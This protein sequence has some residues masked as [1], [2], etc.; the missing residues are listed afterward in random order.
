MK[1]TIL[2]LSLAFATLFS[3]GQTAQEKAKFKNMM[4]QGAKELNQQ[5]PIYVD[6]YTTMTSVIFHNWVWTY[7]YNISFEKELFTDAE[8]KQIINEIKLNTNKQQKRNIDLGLYKCTRAE[9]RWFMKSTGLKF[10]F[11]YIDPNGSLFGLF[12]F[13]YLNY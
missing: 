12:T 1:K 7:T 9:L 5:M 6:E 2:I 4:I 3:F 8:R 13:T 10:R 11:V